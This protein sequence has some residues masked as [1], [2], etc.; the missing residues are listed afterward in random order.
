M[1]K[2]I[3]LALVL[4]LV[5]PAALLVYLSQETRQLS[6]IVRDAATQQPLEDVLLRIGGDLTATNAPG[7]YTL[8]LPRGKFWLA[9]EADR[10]APA[11]VEV[12]ATNLLSRT[13]TLDLTLSL[14][15]VSGVVRDA[16]TSVPLPNA[17]VVLGDKTA[18]SNAQGF[19]EARGVSNNAPIAANVL[20][21]LPVTTTFTGQTELDLAL[22]PNSVVVNVKDKSTNQPLANALIQV[23]TQRA[24]VGA[25]GNATLRRVKPGS[26]IRVSALGYETASNVY[27]GAEI[28]L[29]AL[30]PNVLE[31]TIADAATNQPISGTLVYLGDTII[32]TNAQGKYRLEDVPAKAT[33]SLKAP[34]YQKTLVDVSG[35][36]KRDVKLAPFSVKGIRIPF[37]SDAEHTRELLAL[38]AK[39]ELNALVVDVKSEKGRIAWETQVPLAKQIGAVFRQGVDL[40]QVLE[41]CRAHKIYCIARLPVFQDTLLANAR[42]DLA[43]RY[44]NGVIYSENGGSAWTNPFNADVWT[45]NLALAKE[46]AAMGFDEIQFDYVRFPGKVGNVYY[47]VPYTEDSR[48]AAIAGFLARAQKELRPTGVFISADVFGLTTATEDDQHTGQRLRDLGPYLDYVSPMV[49]P[50]T[51]VNAQDLLLNGLGIPNCTEA[52][53]CPYEVIFNSYKRAAE[54]TTTKVR[55]WLQAY[56]GRGDFGIEQYR[57][58]KKAATDVGSAGWMFWN[59]TGSYDSK[60]FEPKK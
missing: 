33:I 36:A 20:G 52:V 10:Y 25:D 53:R 51:W 54:K 4:V 22:A 18:V 11:Q 46:V 29:V 38:I 49:Y 32:A 43:I 14:N 16:E 41:G 30:R 31:G 58:Q 2:W 59:G 48:I 24:A 7:E 23:D 1:R 5:I 3:L 13:L 28:T 27:T 37:G 12:D 21:Y 19:F 17:Q 44:S 40:V 50:D 55:P 9:A 60:L 42:S 57:I 6:G 26:A 8:P 56:M 45:Y 47:S 35:V 34:G 15:R 39:S